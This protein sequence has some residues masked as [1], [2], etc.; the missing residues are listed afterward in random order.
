[1]ESKVSEGPKFGSI[2]LGDPSN[3]TVKPRGILTNGACGVWLS[4]PIVLSEFPKHDIAMEPLM[5]EHDLTASAAVEHLTDLS[6]K[7][8]MVSYD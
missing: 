7:V 3:A 8:H 6:C 4:S 5:S 1:M 2:A